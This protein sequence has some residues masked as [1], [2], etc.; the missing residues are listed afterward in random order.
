MADK[1][2][3]IYTGTIEGRRVQIEIHDE[4][5]YRVHTTQGADDLGTVE[6]DASSALIVPPTAKGTPITIYGET[7]E[8]I[9]KEL[10]VE[11]FSE[12]GANEIV[13]K[14]PA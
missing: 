11:R 5:G 6:V 10:L 1:W 7:L 14:L 4:G 12:S 2:K 13:G 8:E 9:R 3:S